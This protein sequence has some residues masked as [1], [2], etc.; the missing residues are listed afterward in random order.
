MPIRR[1]QSLRRTDAISSS[2]RLK[3]YFCMHVKAAKFP[4]I[5]HVRAGR[6]ALQLAA[7]GRS[8]FPH[9]GL[10]TKGKWFRESSQLM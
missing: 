4:N 8:P 3:V 5:L 2:V 6:W 7:H 10:L 9:E 1:S